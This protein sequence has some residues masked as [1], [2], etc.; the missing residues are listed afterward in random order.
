MNLFWTVTDRPY[1]CNVEI[2]A[3]GL[4]VYVWCW[5][6]AVSRAWSKSIYY[7]DWSWYMFHRTSNKIRYMFRRSVGIGSKRLYKLLMI[8]DLFRSCEFVT[9]ILQFSFWKYLKK[10]GLCN[11][12][13]FLPKCLTVLPNATTYR[14]LHDF[15]P[16]GRCHEIL[17]KNT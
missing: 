9:L 13:I 4:L 11:K 15:E 14:F 17:V 5:W 2:F 12:H 3:V 1:I 8:F 10:N 6:N 7:V 16:L